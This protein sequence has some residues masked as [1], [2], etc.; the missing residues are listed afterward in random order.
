LRAS[1]ADRE[2]VV[3][4]LKAAFVEDRLTKEELDARVGQ[5]LAS[6]TYADLAAVT[7]DIPAGLMAGQPPREPARAQDRPPMSTAAKAGI[8]VAVAVAV[9]A[10]LSLA[11]GPLVFFMFIPFYFM[12]LL[13]AGAQILFSRYETR[14]RGQLPPRPGQ[15]GIS[16][17]GQRPAPGGAGDDPALPGARPDQTRAD[18]RAHRSRPDRSHSSRRGALTPRGTR[19]V[20]DA[21]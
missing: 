15:G 14:S 21:G 6:R 1:R 19:P 2:Q 12:A 8:S 18:L 4:L 10:V 16:P 20:P 13:I 3:E 5:A 17:Q 9:P 11:V 7:A